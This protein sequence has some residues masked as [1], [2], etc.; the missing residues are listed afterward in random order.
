LYDVG[1]YNICWNT[2]ALWSRAE[3]ANITCLTIGLLPASDECTFLLFNLINNN[4]SLS[5]NN[6]KHFTE[7]ISKL[8]TYTTKMNKVLYFFMYKINNTASVY[9]ITTKS[10]CLSTWYLSEH[11]SIATVLVNVIG[12]TKQNPSLLY[13]TGRYITSVSNVCGK[14]LLTDNAIGPDSVLTHFG[15][16]DDEIVVAGFLSKHWP[17][18]SLWANG[19]AVANVRSRSVRSLTAESR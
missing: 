14:A 10:K 11:I 5:Y 8:L 19:L 18:D 13:L 1:T 4:K 6:E 2:Y 3:L 15:L 9:Q 16:S 12:K 17:A 7:K